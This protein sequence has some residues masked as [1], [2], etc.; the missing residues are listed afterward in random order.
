MLFDFFLWGYIRDIVYE[1]PVT[2]LN[3]LRLRIV[4]TIEAVTPQML[5]NTRGGKMNTAW[6][7]SVP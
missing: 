7:S 4:A 6:T 1:T 5:K 3:E 2:S